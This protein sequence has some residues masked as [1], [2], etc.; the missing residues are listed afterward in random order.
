MKSIFL[1]NL[2]HFCAQTDGSY[3]FPNSQEGDLL[4]TAKKEIEELNN[5][6]ENI[7]KILQSPHGVF[8]NTMRGTITKM[9]DADVKSVYYHLFEKPQ[10]EQDS[11]K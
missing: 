8:I 1:S 11:N 9:R 2:N 7:K 4:K 5:E 10:I 3:N 6:I